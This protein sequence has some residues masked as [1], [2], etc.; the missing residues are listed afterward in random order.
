MIRRNVELLRS[1][2]YNFII[3]ARVRKYSD[4]VKDWILSLPHEDGLFHEYRLDNGDR[5]IVTYNS[6]RAS[7]NA[8]NRIKGVERLK[9]ACASG[10]I[11]KDKINKRGYSK[12]LQIENDVAVSINEDKIK[13]DEKW[14]GMKGYVTNTEPTPKEVVAQYKGLWVVE[15]AFR[16]SKGEFYQFNLS[17]CIRQQNSLTAQFVSFNLSNLANIFYPPQFLQ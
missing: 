13:E 14:D 2:N 15:R 4:K 16:I 8:C 5:L 9:K 10:R 7:K 11:T 6:K 17:S 12:F 1:G 3:G